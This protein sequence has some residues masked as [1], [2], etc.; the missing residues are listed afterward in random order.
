[1]NSWPRNPVILEINTWVWLTELSQAAGTHLTLDT[2][3]TAVWDQLKFLGVDAIWLMGAWQRSPESARIS[4]LDP[5]YQSEFLSVLPDFKDEDNIGSAYAVKSYEVDEFL[6]GTQGMAAARSELNTRGIKL[7]L[8]FVPNHSA[9]DHHWIVEHPEYYIQGEVPALLDGDDAYFETDQKVFACGRDPN[10]L[11]WKDTAQ[12][13]AFHA[14]NRDA[15]LTTLRGIAS[16]CD[17]VRCDMAMLMLNDIFEHTWAEKAGEK[18]PT[19]YWQDV[20]TGV[21]EA[22]PDFYFLAESYWDTDATLIELGFDSC[23]DQKYYD[24]LV[25]LKPAGINTLLNADQKSQQ[26]LVRYIQNHDL[27]PA[28][29]AFT[30]RAGMLAAILMST[31]SGGR[32]YHDGQ[33][34]GR[35]WKTSVFLQRR[36]PEAARPEIQRFYQTIIR[37]AGA[38][39]CKNGQWKMCEKT[40]WTDNQ[41]LQNLITYS[42]NLN[43]STILVACNYS[44]TTSQALVRLPWEYLAGKSWRI[45][46]VIKGDT[47]IRS[48][49]EMLGE[50]MYI[51]LAPWDFHLLWFAREVPPQA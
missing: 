47:F 17:G 16:Q 33:L 35:R 15:A 50:G 24:Q 2:V 11:P 23:Y 39:I 10:F 46:D 27:E 28:A 44:S 38:D 4:N 36:Y 30:T 19:E 41:T 49:D 21:R 37:T 12:L 40:G 48:G 43:Q 8:D 1:M 32:L 51:D 3:P 22:N 14:G 42:W 9:R 26:K 25:K 18:P 7:I 31:T 13:N 6:G 34:D 29:Q 20:I 45:V 5:A